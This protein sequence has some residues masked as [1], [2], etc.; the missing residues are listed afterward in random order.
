MS[1]FTD[2]LTNIRHK[3]LRWLGLDVSEQ[4]PV[5]FV[6]SAE[7]G[8]GVILREP[9]VGLKDG[10]LIVVVDHIFADVPSWVEWDQDRKTMSIMQMGGR[11]EE[12]RIDINPEHYEVLQLARKLLLVSNDNK[13]RIVH[14]VQFIARK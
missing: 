4:T 5:V 13:E 2:F 11:V 1:V 12:V 10:H 8:L 3:L 14:Y 9:L 6:P 7:P